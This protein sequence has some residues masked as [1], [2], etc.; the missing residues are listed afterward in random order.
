MGPCQGGFC[1]YRAAGV[2]HDLSHL[3]PEETNEAL[4]RFLEERWKG[5]KPV[6]WGD[7]LRQIQLDEEIYVNLLGVQRLNDTIEPAAVDRR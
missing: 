1:T 4:S 5:I 2:L 6:L 3:P 7:D